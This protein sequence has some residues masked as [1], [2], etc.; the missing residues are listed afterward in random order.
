M[1]KIQF[2]GF[3]ANFPG[4]RKSHLTGISRKM[5]KGNPGKLTLVMLLSGYLD[6]KNNK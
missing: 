6:M 4:K 2:S 3:P 1:R 5:G